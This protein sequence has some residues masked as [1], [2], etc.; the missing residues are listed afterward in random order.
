MSAV[1]EGD[2]ALRDGQTVHVRPVRE[3]DCDAVLAFLEGLSVES[4]AF[5]F[6]SA[7]ANLRR[8]AEYATAAAGDDRCGLVAVS[9]GRVV[10]HAAYVVER[11]GR[12]EVAFAVADE[13]Q[14]HGIATILLA[15]LVEAAAEAGIQTLTAVVM[16]DNRR[17]IEVFRDSGL[18]VSMS[19]GPGEIR[20]EMPAVL[21][22]SALQRFAERDRTAAAAAVAHVLEPTSIAVVGASERDGSIGGT[23]LSNLREFGFPGP[24]W[25]VHP[26]A[27]LIRGVRAVPSLSAI[28]APVELAV[29]AVPA[30]RVLDVAR[31]AAGA[32]VRALIVVSAGFAE[33]DSEGARRQE[34][35]LAVCRDAGIR[36]VGPNCLG[37]LNTGAK[38]DAT[39]APNLPVAGN[40]GF[41]S[42]SGALGVAA[43]DLA[44]RR[45]LGLSS[46]ASVGNKAD[47]S[48]NDFL[49]YWEHD[50]GTSAVMLYLES[51]G[52]PRKF[53]RIA[54]RMGRTKPIVVVKAGRGV[55]GE[56][57]AHSH[58]GALL[59]ASDTTVDALCTQAGVIRTETLGELFDVGALLAH[60]PA[61][62]GPRVAI[63]TNGGGLGIL[64]ADACEAA[65]LEVP[66]LPE[67]LRN[68]L[69]RLV[70]DAASLG[71]P[72]DL[73]ATAPADAFATVVPKLA[74]SGDVDAIVVLYVPALGG[75]LDG[76][77]GAVRAAADT[78]AGRVPVAAVFVTPDGT[79]K[80]LADGI[81]PCFEYP[82]DAARAL[83]RSARYGA[84]R[85][86]E[87]G[88][89]PELPDARSD[90]ATAIL[91]TAL[92][93]GDEWLPAAEL[94]RLLDCYGIPVAEL[95]PAA[96]PVA[97]GA[98]A[99]ALGG[100]VALKAVAPGLVHKYDVGGV[101]LGLR[102]EARVARAATAMRERLAAAGY[103]EATFMVQRMAPAGVELLAGV[104]Q[105]GA[106]GPVLACGAGGVTA[107]LTGD[108]A[109]RLAPIED[110]DAADMLR[111]LRC[112]ALL[113]GFRGSPPS[114]VAAVEDVLCRLGVLAD[115]HPELAEVELNPL[116]AW[117]RGAVA[118]DGRARLRVPS[119]RPPVASM[120]A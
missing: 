51:F 5:R 58:T 113:E 15:Q 93:R 70:P 61:P 44:R 47:L 80:P 110:R 77:A 95:R 23:I 16:P 11:P 76:V 14:G 35:L 41:L 74:D 97:A 3:E 67:E 72:L 52:N 79:P 29:V 57:A 91:A 39:F 56:R 50:P 73:L 20:L 112:F 71:N 27:S 108:V 94:W 17:M 100:T 55:A 82:E 75:D 2:I 7:G 18:D 92:G 36:L 103:A 12:A 107:E 109:A 46:F 68:E 87:P 60:T 63:V 1:H 90:E 65:G 4:R 98:A 102:G 37:V 10:A 81:V 13:L 53:S 88:V 78:V 118:V 99:R 120:R 105:E 54:R 26:R 86:K 22:P 48:G 30:P 8:M 34:A 6:F 66:A 43:M 106:F 38:L 33:S 101:A 85:A 116:V 89:V 64:C 104:V 62:R 24:L 21:E 40:V 9:S 111:E 114:D 59:D 31:D 119:P 69:R 25:A 45:N 32:G 19:A 115:R 49:Q 42:Q 96:D 28:P 84:W 117:E 83:G